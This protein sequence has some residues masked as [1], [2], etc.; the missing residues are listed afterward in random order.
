MS[1]ARPPQGAWCGRARW[2]SSYRPTQ[3]SHCPQNL[4]PPTH[5]HSPHLPPQPGALGLRGCCD[6]RP[7]LPAPFRGRG[8]PGAATPPPAHLP[9]SERGQQDRPPHQAGPG[10]LLGHCRRRP[11]RSAPLDGGQGRV[12]PSHEPTGA[13]GGPAPWLGPTCKAL[14]YVLASRG[15]VPGLGSHPACPPAPSI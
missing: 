3:V 15:S 11:C 12:G 13:R 9:G 8:L 7:V 2:P 4:L 1:R 14:T 5:P 6:H 10:R